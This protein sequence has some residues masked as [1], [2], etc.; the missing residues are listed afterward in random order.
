MI[1]QKLYLCFEGL[2]LILCPAEIITRQTESDKVAVLKLILLI[3]D[4]RH[5]RSIYKC[6]N[7]PVK[8]DANEFSETMPLLCK[9]VLR[10][11][12][13]SKQKAPKPV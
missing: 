11:E 1:S 10:L 13:S 12:V 3:S 2:F 5:W 7:R 6:Q 9:F 8:I 4:R